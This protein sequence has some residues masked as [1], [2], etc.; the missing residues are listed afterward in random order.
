AT[1]AE[2]SRCQVFHRRPEPLPGD[3]APAPGVA[4]GGAA[5]AVN[6]PTGGGPDGVGEMGGWSPIGCSFGERSGAAVPYGPAVTTRA[7][8]WS[9]RQLGPARPQR[10]RRTADL[11]CHGLAGRDRGDGWMS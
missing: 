1:P 10:P 2:A 6:V 4:G 5:G 7:G 9:R 11:I 3:G 8:S